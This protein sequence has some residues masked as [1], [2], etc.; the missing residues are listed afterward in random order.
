MQTDKTNIDRYDFKDSVRLDTTMQTLNIVDGPWNCKKNML[1]E[2]LLNKV[3]KKKL[4]N[5]S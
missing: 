3:F 4:F 1:L 2:S 5:L